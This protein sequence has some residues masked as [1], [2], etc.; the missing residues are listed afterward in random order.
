[1]Q[2]RW[3]AILESRRATLEKD[4]TGFQAL[5]RAWAV[6]RW[7]RRVTG[8]KVGGKEKVRRARGGW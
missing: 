4:V 3:R 1:L 2:Q 5:A 8:G 6:R 7:A